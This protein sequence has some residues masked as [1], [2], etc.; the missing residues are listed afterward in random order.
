MGY[1]E[2]CA[3]RRNSDGVQGRAR[4]P[5][6]LDWFQRAGSDAVDPQDARGAQPTKRCIGRQHSL[7]RK[8]ADRIDRLRASEPD[9]ARPDIPSLDQREPA[10]AGYRESPSTRRVGD[11]ARDATAPRVS[12]VRSLPVP[13][14]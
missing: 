4:K 3:C 6:T 8:P 11:G 10:P 2:A 5:P 14:S 1:D 7:G 12:K 9:A 13:R